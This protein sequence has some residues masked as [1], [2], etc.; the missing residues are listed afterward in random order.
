MLGKPDGQEQPLLAASCAI[1]RQLPSPIL[2]PPL[3]SARPNLSA[4]NA[5]ATLIVN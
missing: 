5:S 2:V 3:D 1:E 4:S